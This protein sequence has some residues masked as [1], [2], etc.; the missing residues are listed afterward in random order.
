[1]AYELTGRAV[2]VWPV[3]THAPDAVIEQFRFLLTPDETDRAGRFR[4]DHLRRSFILARGALRVLLGRYL[5]IAPGGIEFSYGSKGKPALAAPG[6]PQFNVL[7]F[8]ASHS[9]DLALFAF[10]MDCEVGVDVEAI[11]PMP[12]LEDVAKRFFCAEENAELM[13]LPA[14][15]RERGFF[16]CWTRKEAYIKAT[17]EGLSTPL[18]AF[19]VTLQPSEPAGM[20][21]LERDPIAAQAW[22]LHDLAPAPGYAAALAYRD[23]PRPLEILPFFNPK[24]LL[25]IA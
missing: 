23:S 10:T 8:N 22:T 19:R 7:Q 2:H 18:D 6:L 9:G 24:Q 16:L 4:F 5:N 25:D 17:G 12:D 3:S 20:V 14:G 21:H 11:R 13:A 15:Q 1:M